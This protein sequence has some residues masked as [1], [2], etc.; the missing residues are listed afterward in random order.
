MEVRQQVQYNFHINVPKLMCTWWDSQKSI[1]HV[2]GS[3]TRGQ[4]V[5]QSSMVEGKQWGSSSPQQTLIFDAIP[6]KITCTLSMLHC[7]IQCMNAMSWVYPTACPGSFF[8]CCA[9]SPQC[10]FWTCSGILHIFSTCCIATHCFPP[11][12]LTDFLTYC[13]R[14][15]RVS[16]SW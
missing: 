14:A 16:C 4:K 9:F 8:G 1:L 2:K 3:F 11:P 15:L 7:Y 12:C 6:T 13:E 10:F 5:N